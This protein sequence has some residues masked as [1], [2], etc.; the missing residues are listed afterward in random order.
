MPL[1]ASQKCLEDGHGPDMFHQLDKSGDTN[2]QVW[3]GFSE[4]GLNHL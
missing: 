3:R 1:E 2:G 4:A